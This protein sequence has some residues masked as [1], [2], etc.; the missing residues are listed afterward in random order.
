MNMLGKILVVL[1]FIMS[2]FFMA[3]SFMVFSTQTSWKDKAT[4]AKSERDNATTANNQLQAEVTRIKTERAAANA[5]RTRAI[6]L[7]EANLSQSGQQ[8]NVMQQELEVL[9]SK[10]AQQGAQVTGSLATLQAERQKVDS[11]REAVKMAQGERDKM[12]A[13][14]VNLKNSVLQL[15]AIRQR[16]SASETALLD[17]VGRQ[18]SV[19]RANDLNA[20]DDI[21]GVPPKRD[22]KV[23]QVDTTNKYVVLSLGSDD[24]MRKGH[25]LDVHR[26]Q[27]YLGKVQLTKT[28]PDRSIAV[29]LDD[30]R[31]GAIRSGDSV[32]TK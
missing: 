8:I 15:E 12:F 32:R 20:N 18:A 25:K 26:G 2:I 7:L 6:A 10:Q 19:L 9:R 23:R 11:L 28:H 22:G 16:L 3:F 27:K 21:S 5:A 31:K 14:V 30:Y 29:V 24:G 17:Q 1:I 4:Q 13:D